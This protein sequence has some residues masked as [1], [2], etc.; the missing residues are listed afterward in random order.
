M[1]LLFEFCFKLT[2]DTKATRCSRL[3]F[4]VMFVIQELVDVE[5]VEGTVAG[6]SGCAEEDGRVCVFEEAGEE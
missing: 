5:E 1:Y 3:R 4:F 2:K 6:E